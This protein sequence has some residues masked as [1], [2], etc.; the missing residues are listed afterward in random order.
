MTQTKS[1]S[2]TNHQSVCKG[3]L[4][5]NRKEIK[6]TVTPWLRNSFIK[7]IKPVAELSPSARST[8]QLFIHYCRCAL[9]E[10]TAKLNNVAFQLHSHL[11]TCDVTCT[12]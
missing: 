5:R 8:I 1:K 11:I 3:E 10:V 2:Q 4:R 12:A 9:I 7:E 6:C